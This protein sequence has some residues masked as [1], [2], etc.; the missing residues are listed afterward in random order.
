ML[1]HATNDGLCDEYRSPN[2]EAGEPTEG[3]ETV[4]GPL[5]KKIA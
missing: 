1:F 2:P 3:Q 5:L 4:S